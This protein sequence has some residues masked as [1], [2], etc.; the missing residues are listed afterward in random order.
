MANSVTETAVGA[1]VLA[2]AIGFLVY[3][4]G[5]VDNSRS[6]QGTEITAQ[7]RS[8]EGISVGTDVKL[9]GV[10]IGTVT[11]ITLDPQTYLAKTKVIVD[12]AIEIPDD[13]AISI[14]SEGLLGGS[15]VEIIPGA[16]EF[17]VENG[18]ELEDT[19]SSISL[20]TLLMRFIGG[21]GQ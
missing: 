1:G 13:S 20:I 16:S 10:K 3:A 11:G 6:S 17:S 7:F 15:F 12:Q 21:D 5:Y 19:Q 14:E 2:L 8:V 18:G 9:G 4:S